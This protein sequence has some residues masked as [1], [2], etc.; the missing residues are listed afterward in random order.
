ALGRDLV[1][2]RDVDDVDGEIG[3]LGREGGGEIV[4]ARL[5][6]DQ[7]ERGKFLPH[8]G[9]G[10]EVDRGILADRRV[11]AAAGL[12]P[13][14]A[15]GRERA[16]AHQ[17]F[18]VPLGVD[19]VGDGGDLVGAAPALAQRVHQR[20]LA[21]ADRAADA[22]PQR[23]VGILR[24]HDR[25][26][27]VYWVS[28]R[29]PARSARN[30][31]PPTSSSGVSSA[32]VAVAETA[33]SSAASTRWPSVW[34]SGMRRTPADTRLAAAACTNA[35]TLGASGTPWPAAATPTATG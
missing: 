8:L 19:V 28:W 21:R 12:H 34:P 22:D 14:D 30:A 4:A 26:S 15:L 29:M 7:V 20:R 32:R 2:G 25:N 18:G 17:V 35:A 31:A 33:P 24:G 1:A 16:R 5:D 13:G 10:G 6:Q 27:R 9:D 23:T 11:R 3:E